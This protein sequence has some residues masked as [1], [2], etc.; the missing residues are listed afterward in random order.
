[1]APDIEVVKEIKAYIWNTDYEVMVSVAK[2]IDVARRNIDNKIIEMESVGIIDE[3]SLR[4]AMELSAFVAANE[5]FYVLT[6][7]ESVVYDHSNE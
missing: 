3:G 7:N 6:L 5:P 2:D 1:M 4:R